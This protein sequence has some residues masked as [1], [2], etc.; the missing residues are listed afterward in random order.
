MN[1]TKKREGADEGRRD[2]LRKSAYAAYA[3]PVIMAMLVEKANA[4]KSWNPGRGN[5][6]NNGKAKPPRGNGYGLS[7]N[8]RGG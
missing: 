4:A 1:E 5:I 3:T 7:N 2:F 6:P 8:G